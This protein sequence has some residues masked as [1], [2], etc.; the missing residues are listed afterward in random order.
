M[1]KL[2]LYWLVAKEWLSEKY[3]SGEAVDLLIMIG[4]GICSLGLL[5]VILF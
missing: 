2:K 4:I 1:R 3:N 5:S